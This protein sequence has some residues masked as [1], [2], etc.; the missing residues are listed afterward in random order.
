MCRAWTLVK[1]N[2]AV[3]VAV[4]ALLVSGISATFAYLSYDVGRDNLRFQHENAKSSITFDR[5]TLDLNDMDEW[6]F[7]LGFH[8]V[9]YIESGH[10]LILAANQNTFNTQIL[11]KV[12]VTNSMARGGSAEAHSPLQKKLLGSYII[13]CVVLKDTENMPHLSEYYYD[14][15]TQTEIYGPRSLY[16]VGSEIANKIRASH[17][18]PTSPTTS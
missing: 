12:E 4:L 3:I 16:G 18:C 14:M 5:V 9:N 10:I 2:R 13:L 7:H 1:D 11:R 15:P 17:P 6:L 8:A